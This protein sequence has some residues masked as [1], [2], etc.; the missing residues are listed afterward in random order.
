MEV[1]YPQPVKLTI[2]QSPQNILYQNNCFSSTK[3]I[4][5]N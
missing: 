2:R 4:N 1:T 3:L 5:K